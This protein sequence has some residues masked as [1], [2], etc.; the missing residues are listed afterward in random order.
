MNSDSIS[1]W[2]FSEDEL[3]AHLFHGFLHFLW[4]GIPHMRADRPLMAEGIFHFA[5]AVAPRHVVERHR[6]FRAGA[7]RLFEE[8]INIPDVEMWRSR[9]YTEDADG[10]ESGFDA[11]FS[12]V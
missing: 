2:I 4:T 6:A 5:V 12:A 7:D 11:R 8:G 10:T 3:G 9:S 1:N